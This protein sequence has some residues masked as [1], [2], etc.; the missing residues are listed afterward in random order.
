MTKFGVTKE[1]I[2]QILANGVP[3]VRGKHPPMSHALTLGERWQIYQE[4]QK[5]DRANAN[6]PQR[7]N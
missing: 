1:E 3:I 2:L 7:R 6:A 4:R 5:E